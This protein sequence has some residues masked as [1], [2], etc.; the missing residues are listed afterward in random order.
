MECIR[1]D[2]A[3][4][5]CDAIDDRLIGLLIV[6]VQDHSSALGRRAYSRQL[7]WVLAPLV[8]VFGED[9]DVWDN[10]VDERTTAVRDLVGREQERLQKRWPVSVRR[11]CI[12]HTRQWNSHLAAG[13]AAQ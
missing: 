5:H 1:D 3:H 8:D 12:G 11:M 6:L 7:I 10:F 4:T 13:A 9:I 2:S